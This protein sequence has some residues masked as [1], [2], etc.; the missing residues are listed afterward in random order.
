MGVVGRIPRSPS[1]KDFLPCSLADMWKYHTHY[2]FTLYPN[3]I[4]INHLK[5]ESFY[6]LV[7]EKL[8]KIPSV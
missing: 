8:K 3:W 4:L 6:Q 2:Y 1:P 5:A 7:E